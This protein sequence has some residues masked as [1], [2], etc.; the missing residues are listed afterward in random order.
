MKVLTW[1]MEL[2]LAAQALVNYVLSVKKG[3]DVLI[4]GDDANDEA[5]LKATAAAVHAAGAT[6]TMVVYETRK[7]S[8]SEPPKPLAAAMMDSDVVIEFSVKAILYTQ[9]QTNALRRN[10]AYIC[11]TSLDREA[12][13]RTLGWVNYPKMV[14][15]GDKLAELTSRADEIRVTSPSGTDFTAK[16]GGRKFE[17]FGGTADKRQVIMLG[18]QTGG[19]PIEETENGVLAFDGNVWPPD[20]I[21][22]RITTPIKFRV[23]KGVIKEISGGA[24]ADILR[25]FLAGF[26][27]PNMYR[28]AHFCYGYH[29]MARVTGDIAEVERVWGAF[30]VGWGTQG[31]LL[32]PDLGGKYGWKAASHDDGIIL[33]ASIY[34]DGEPVQKDGKFVHPELVKIIKDMGV[35][36]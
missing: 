4:Y 31:P 34:L 20:E 24:E 6:P 22:N 7:Q 32:R 23:E 8:F 15:M 11:L 1:Y 3:E 36:Q 30:Q 13:V 35:E 29:P 25:R 14:E 5:V 16:I 28:I 18:G 26:K 19:S 17:N 27:D 21:K 2:G 10:R 9:A 33:K 12:M